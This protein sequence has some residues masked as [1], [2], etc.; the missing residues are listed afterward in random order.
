MKD[1]QRKAIHAK[2]GFLYLTNN[3]RI[4]KKR[5]DRARPTEFGCGAKNCVRGVEV[6]DGGIC[7]KCKGKG[8]Q[9]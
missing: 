9:S 3:P 7:P 8:K 1:S 2:K 4:N 5:L 6:I